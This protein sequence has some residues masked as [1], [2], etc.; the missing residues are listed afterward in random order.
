MI[1]WI[2][3]FRR[4]KSNQMLVTISL[5]YVSTSWIGWKSCVET[6]FESVWSYLK[7]SICFWSVISFKVKSWAVLPL[8]IWLILKTWKND[9]CISPC[10]EWTYIW[11]VSYEPSGTLVV[12]MSSRLSYCLYK[13]FLSIFSF[14][15]NLNLVSDSETIFSFNFFFCSSR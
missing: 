8:K 6:I 11:W 7:F 1:I 14:F 12:K 15:S 13:R 10:W 5:N 4:R 3:V 2:I 9:Y